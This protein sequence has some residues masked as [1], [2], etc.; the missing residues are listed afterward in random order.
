MVLKMGVRIERWKDGKFR[1]VER[2]E[3]GR[4]KSWSF[5]Q[6]IY[7]PPYEFK[8]RKKAYFNI[9]YDVRFKVAYLSDK[10]PNKNRV[11][12]IAGIVISPYQLKDDQLIN[13]LIDEVT[14]RFETWME[15]VYPNKIFDIHIYASLTDIEVLDV[16]I[17]SVKWEDLGG[18]GA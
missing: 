16:D 17:Y 8:P 18:W 12:A 14:Q 10:K 11:G 5:V 4:F 7:V 9:Q 1:Y 6:D 3:K 13:M 15:Y 2:D